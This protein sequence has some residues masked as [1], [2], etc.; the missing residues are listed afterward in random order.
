MEVNEPMQ[1]EIDTEILETIFTSAARS[2]VAPA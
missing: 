2:W 1:I